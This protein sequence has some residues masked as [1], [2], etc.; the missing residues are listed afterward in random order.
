MH[1]HLTLAM[2]S[3]TIG[4]S[5]LSQPSS[6]VATPSFVRVGFTRY[7]I[8]DLGTLGGS[9][10]SGVGVNGRGEVAGESVVSSG[11]LHAFVWSDGVMRDLG[12]LGEPSSYAFVLGI[13]ERGQLV[14]PASDGGQNR[15][16]G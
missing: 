11:V 1:R 6:G 10:S 8:I 16:P 5:Q 4:C 14:F 7:E 2:A 9:S 13:N 15:S 12:T 3:A